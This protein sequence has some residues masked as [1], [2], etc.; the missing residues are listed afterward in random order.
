MAV[1]DHLC[2]CFSLWPH[3]YHLPNTNGAGLELLVS[4]GSTIDV[5]TTVV[6]EGSRKPKYF[7]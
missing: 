4:D 5:S 3:A 7:K 2:P 1:Y 6:V